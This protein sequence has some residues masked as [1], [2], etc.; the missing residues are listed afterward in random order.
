[1]KISCENYDKEG[2][3]GG[4]PSVRILCVFFKKNMSTN[5]HRIFQYGIVESEKGVGRAEILAENALGNGTRALFVCGGDLRAVACHARYYCAAWDKTAVRD[6]YKHG[7]GA[8]KLFYKRAQGA[9][10]ISRISKPVEI[11]IYASCAYFK[12]RRETKV[13]VLSRGER[14]HL[15]SRTE[16]AADCF[17]IAAHFASGHRFAFVGDKGAF[18]CDKRAYAHVGKGKRAGQAI[19]FSRKSEIAYDIVVVRYDRVLRHRTDH[20]AFCAEFARKKSYI[21]DK[22]LRDYP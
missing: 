17:E 12:V 15:S 18:I 20:F 8:R 3:F 14:A 7:V 10:V 5:E 1:M 21:H 4:R 22:V 19:E 9:L 6:G 16:F 2:L 11:E 13:S